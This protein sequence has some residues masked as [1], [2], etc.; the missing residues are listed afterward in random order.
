LTGRQEIDRIGWEGKGKGKR[1]KGK[2]TESG[3]ADIL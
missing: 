3:K 1:S 2:T